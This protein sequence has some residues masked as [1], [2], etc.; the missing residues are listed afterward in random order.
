MGSD[1]KMRWVKLVEVGNV[2]TAYCQDC[3]KMVRAIAKN[4]DVPFDDGVGI[5]RQ[6]IVFVCEA[7]DVVCAIP[8]QATPAIAEARKAALAELN[9]A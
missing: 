2:C 6:I 5:V 3:D 4:Q 8:A 7:C 1:Q 9:K